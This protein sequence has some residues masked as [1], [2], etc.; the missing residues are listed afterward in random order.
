MSLLDLTGIIDEINDAEEPTYLEKGTEANL[1]IVSVRTGTSDKNGCDWFSPMYE[2]MDHPLAMEFNSFLWAPDKDKLTPKQYARALYD[3]KVFAKA[4]G[5][6]LSKPIDYEDDL[7]GN[8]GWAILGVQK[9]EE[10]GDRNTIGK[11]I[12]PK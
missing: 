5:I 6:D 9:D 12:A 7:P 3:I 1:R 4:F 2:V 11:F 8:T 10:Y